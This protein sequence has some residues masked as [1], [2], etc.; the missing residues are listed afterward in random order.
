MYAVKYFCRWLKSDRGVYQSQISYSTNRM[1][2][3][4]CMC[5][6]YFQTFSFLLAHVF[7]ST[8]SCQSSSPPTPF[9]LMPSCIQSMHLFCLF[10][11]FR[12]S[13][14]LPFYKLF[15]LL[16]EGHKVL[17]ADCLRTS[18]SYI[19]IRVYS[20]HCRS[21]HVCEYRNLW[22]EAL[23]SILGQCLASE[24]P[25]PC[26][27]VWPYDLSMPLSCFMSRYCLEIRSLRRSGFTT[28][29][30]YFVTKQ[31]WLFLVHLMDKNCVLVRENLV[32]MMIR[33]ATY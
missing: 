3:C 6:H 22:Q 1:V 30:H 9:L 15:C 18:Q 24:K 11:L 14:K 28:I 16:R 2:K 26:H 21:R 12:H 20:I 10:F 5:K 19:D 27:A 13:L 31:D 8:F 33:I 4:Y 32:V 23:I 29:P 25:L 7:F 17:L